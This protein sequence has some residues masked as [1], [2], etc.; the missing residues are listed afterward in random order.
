MAVIALQSLY[1]ILYQLKHYPKIGEI[2]V[3]FPLL[4]ERIET[5]TPQ[6]AGQCPPQQAAHSPSMA[7][8][9]RSSELFSA[10]EKNAQLAQ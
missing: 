3:H 5:N 4:L 2:Q 1:I 10:A 9:Q 7:R 6:H 8:Q